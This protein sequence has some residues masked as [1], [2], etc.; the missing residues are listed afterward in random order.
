M[1]SRSA[2]GALSWGEQEKNTKK[3]KNGW[4]CPSRLSR[5]FHRF[6][7][8][9]LVKRVIAKTSEEKKKE[10]KDNANNH[11][12]E[13]VNENLQRSRSTFT[14]ASSAFAVCVRH[15]HIGYDLIAPW[16]E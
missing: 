7:K 6:L 16:L 5:I 9:A 11:S 14:S 3:R 8:S 13:F 2:D 10:D 12:F 15:V 1:Q 4:E